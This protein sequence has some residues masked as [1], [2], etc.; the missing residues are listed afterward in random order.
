MVRAAQGYDSQG[1][2]LKPKPEEVRLYLNVCFDSVC[3]WAV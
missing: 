1:A 2:G 3:R